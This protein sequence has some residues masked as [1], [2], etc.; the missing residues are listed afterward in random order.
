[1]RGRRDRIVAKAQP[2]LIGDANGADKIVQ[3]YLKEHGFEKVEVCEGE[4]RPVKAR[5]GGR[6]AATRLR[7]RRAPAD[8]ATAI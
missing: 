2:V 3:R 4:S 8:A 1:V 5:D 6:R 7:P